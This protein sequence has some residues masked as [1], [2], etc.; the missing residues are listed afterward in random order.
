MKLHY[1]TNKYDYTNGVAVSEPETHTETVGTDNGDG[2]WTIYDAKVTSVDGTVTDTIAT[3]AFITA[4]VSLST[5][6]YQVSKSSEGFKIKVP[7]NTTKV[8]VKAKCGTS[9]KTGTENMLKIG[10]KTFSMDM[11]ANYTDYEA[12][13]EEIG[14]SSETTVS[15]SN[16]H[17]SN[18]MNI[19]E[20]KVIA[21]GAWST[22]YTT[23]I[24]L[25]DIDAYEVDSRDAQV[26]AAVTAKVG[27]TMYS[28]FDVALGDSGMGVSIAVTDPVQA[29]DDVMLYAGRHNPDF[30]YQFT[31]ST[32]DT[33]YGVNSALKALVVSYAS[34][35]TATQGTSASST[36]GSDGTDSE[37]TDGT[38]DSGDS[39]NTET[40][41]ELGAVAAGTYNM[42]V[43]GGYTKQDSNAATQVVN[44]IAVSAKV[45]TSD[46]VLKISSSA[47]QG[48]VKFKIDSSMTLV[49]T[50]STSNG[51][52]IASSDGTATVD[53]TTVS[54][55]ELPT[56]KNASATISGKTMV[57]TAGTYELGG[58]TSSGSKLTQLVFTAN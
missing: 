18:S 56:S 35:L 51:I 53:G 15:I 11:T 32:D 14:I 50:E 28:N 40:T 17:S 1:I 54:L 19:R 43:A 7:A 30:A 34:G 42:T 33:D 23:G 31:N 16:A 5:D 44:N 45:E 25:S 38:D 13:A 47:Q 57:L 8:I 10:N 29:K 12:S 46:V 52:A 20:I 48:T 24:S 3:C 22:T 41:V 2:T 37:N 27:G 55:S 36:S 49:V 39:G 58:C 4:N 21:S 6:K 9:N 26:P